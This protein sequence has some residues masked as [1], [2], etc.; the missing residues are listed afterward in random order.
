MTPRE[1]E[2]ETRRADIA[3][4]D[5]ELATLAM[6]HEYAD[7]QGYVPVI[8]ADRLHHEIYLSDAR[9]VTPEKLKT[10]IMHPIRKRQLNGGAGMISS[11][12]V[13]LIFHF[14]CF[15]LFVSPRM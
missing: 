3:P 10:V 4:Y 11:G 8:T 6:M 1:R 7:R 12:T 9:K 14:I 2:E 13:V 5:T 15:G